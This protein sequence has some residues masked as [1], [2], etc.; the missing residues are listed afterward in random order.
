MI[1]VDLTYRRDDFA[2]KAQFSTRTRITGLVGPSGAG[3]STLLNLIA[4]LLRPAE[5]FIKINGEL[6]HCSKRNKHVPAHRRELGVVF[7]DARLLPHYSVKGNLRYGMRD[8]RASSPPAFEDVVELLD[9]QNLL[10]RKPGHLSGGEQQRVALGRALLRRPRALLLDEPLAS[11][12]VM[13][14]RAVLPYLRKVV[15]T[16]EVPVLYVSH[17]QREILQL[18]DT[19]LVMDAGA[20]VGHGTP[21]D[22][23]QDDS[24]WRTLHALGMQNV[25]RLRVAAHDHDA[26]LTQLA[27]TEEGGSSC[28]LNA[29]LR[30]DLAPGATVQVAISP[31]DIALALHEVRDTS[32]Q[33]QVPG[34]I[35][36]LTKHAD[37]TVL[38]VETGARLLVEVSHRTV[39]TMDLA[40]GQD[41]WCLIKSNAVMYV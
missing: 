30:E 22:L 12:D 21:G 32:I 25:L 5:G 27:S 20:I 13:R 16:V 39:R 8:D 35:T 23:V 24:A 38:E 2:V 17:D 1:Q 37:R 11:L 41:L 4:G 15:E 31:V 26:G 34:R 3:K 40:T 9:L 28:V 6:V 29:P 18:T 36:M 33:N 10:T 7:Q 14:K 19:L